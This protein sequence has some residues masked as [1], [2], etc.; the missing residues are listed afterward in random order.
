MRPSRSRAQAGDQRILHRLAEG[1]RLRQ[2]RFGLLAGAEVARQQH[3]HGDERD[4]QAGDQRR[5]HV[6]EH[7]GQLAR[8]LQPQH[9]GGAGQVD[10]LLRDEHPRAAPRHALHGQAR[11]VQFG[12]AHA[13]PTRQAAGQQRQHAIQRVRGHH[14]ALQLR[15]LPHGQAQLQHLLAQAAGARH[16]AAGRIGRR[17]QLAGLAAQ[18]GDVGGMVRAAV[19]RR[20]CQRGVERAVG[21]RAQVQRRV[22]P[23][24]AHPFA[25][26][27]QQ[28]RGARPPA[29]RIGMRG[30]QAVQI[31]QVAREPLAQHLRGVGVVAV[32]IALRLLDL[33]PTRQPHQ[34]GQQ[35]H[36][37]Q[38]Q[39]EPQGPAAPRAAQPGQ[40]AGGCIGRG[41]ASAPGRARHG[42]L[43]NS[44]GKCLYRP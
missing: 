28:L 41:H 6:G 22:V 39:R 9:D 44:S 24:Q 16:E 10:D 5:E 14:V 35:P 32:Q 7:V 12:E 36:H 25:V 33:V 29:D 27:A 26:L 31:L 18:V 15:A 38:H 13:L 30:R 21:H 20:R 1:Q 40:C 23:L 3:Q 37:H 17:A 19:G 2:F 34:R 43:E 11:A 42:R 8:A 4:R